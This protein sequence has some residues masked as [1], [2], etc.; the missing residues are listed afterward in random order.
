MHRLPQV[1]LQLWSGALLL[2]DALLADPACVAG[3]RVLELGAG[4]GLASLVRGEDRA[5]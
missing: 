1:G 2:A 3:R 5:A 4:V